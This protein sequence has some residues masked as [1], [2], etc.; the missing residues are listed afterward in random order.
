[1]KRNDRKYCVWKRITVAVLA[2]LLAIGLMGCSLEDV[3]GV[4]NSS[5]I[6]FDDGYT[7]PTD[8]GVVD[9]R[10]GIPEVDDFDDLRYDPI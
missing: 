1:M 7:A 8:M 10:P 6:P 9:N 4:F 3:F 5:D 2:V